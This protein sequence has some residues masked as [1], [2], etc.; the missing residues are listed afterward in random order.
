MLASYNANLLASIP[1]I[2]IYQFIYTYKKE[3]PFPDKMH[4]STDLKNDPKKYVC[5]LKTYKEIYIIFLNIFEH[6]I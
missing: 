3:L 4:F 1:W 6:N 5:V 2:K